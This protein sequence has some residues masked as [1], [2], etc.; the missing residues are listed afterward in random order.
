MATQ[1]LRRNDLNSVLLEGTLLNDPMKTED[2][3]GISFTIK[4]ESTAKGRGSVAVPVFVP[5]EGRYYDL[6]STL[7]IG[8][9]V[10]I[11]GFL[12][13]LGVFNILGVMAE[14]IEIQN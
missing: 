10:R 1:N 5:Q 13:P 2:P 9:A 3:I 11:V 4:T 12:H 6:C 7:K 14:H 8:Q